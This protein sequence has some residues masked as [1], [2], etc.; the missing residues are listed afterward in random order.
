MSQHIKEADSSVTEFEDKF[1]G[2]QKTKQ[3][4]K[5]KKETIFNKLK[6]KMDKRNVIPTHIRLIYEYYNTYIVR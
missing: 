5:K 2:T 3:T 6:G 4:K 1:V